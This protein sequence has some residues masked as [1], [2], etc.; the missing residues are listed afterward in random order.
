M[1]FLYYHLC[2]A[3]VLQQQ[4]S[5]G[6][7]FRPHQRISVIFH[8]NER[9]LFP[10]TKRLRQKNQDHPVL[11][12]TT[13][14]FRCRWRMIQGFRRNTFSATSSDLLLA[15]S[16]TVPNIR[17]VL[18]GLVQASGS[19][20]FSVIWGEA[21]RSQI[22]SAFLLLIDSRFSGRSRASGERARPKK[23]LSQ[24]PAL[25][26]FRRNPVG[27]EMRSDER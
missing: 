1:R 4:Q 27:N 18:E 3:T 12:G 26:C 9:G 22:T 15:R 11:C 19:T 16:V 7:M 17:G 24:T 6:I 10:G 25:C 2:T 14:S 20:P 21:S 23:V 8:Q 13:R 5:T